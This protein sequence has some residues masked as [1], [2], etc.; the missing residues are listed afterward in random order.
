MKTKYRVLALVLIS[1][2]FLCVALVPWVSAESGEDSGSVPH[3]KKSLDEVKDQIRKQGLHWTAKETALSNLT[4]GETLTKTG[5]TRI[6]PGTKISP[7]E[8]AEAT[9]PV[10]SGGVLPSSFDWRANPGNYVTA[11]KDQGCGDC[12]AFASA[13]AD[14]K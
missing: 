14:Q 1:T 9:V 13:A 4:D 2:L 8:S 11:V 6:D 7:G 3:E 10:V 5:G 12:W